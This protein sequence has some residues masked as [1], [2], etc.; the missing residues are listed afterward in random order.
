M[1]SRERVQLALDHIEPDRV[2]LDLGASATTGM[3]VSSVYKLRQALSLPRSKRP[4]V[5]VQITR[6]SA[7]SLDSLEDDKVGAA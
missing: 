3:H 1:K 7:Q 6:L 4:I 2:P 5:E